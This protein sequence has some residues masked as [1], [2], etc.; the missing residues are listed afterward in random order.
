MNLVRTQIVWTLA[1]VAAFVL[2]AE[3]SLAGDMDLGWD[4]VPQSDVAG[5][6]ISYDTEPGGNYRSFIDTSNVTSFTLQG[7]SNCTRYHVAIRARDTGGLLSPAFSN[8][9]SGFPHPSIVSMTPSS[10]GRGASADVVISGRNF[11]PG[12]TATLPNVMVDSTAVDSCGQM[13]VH[14]TVGPAATGALTLTVRNVDGSSA[15]LPG[16]LLVSGTPAAFEITSVSPAAGASSVDA[17]QT[18]QV[19]FSQPVKPLTVTAPRFRLIRVGGGPSPRLEAGTPSLDA[20]GTTVSLRILGTLVSGAFYYLHVRGG[21][22]GVLDATG[23]PLGQNYV[24]SP[25]FKIAPLLEGTYYGP[26][27]MVQ[28]GM[29]PLPPLTANATIPTASV[30]VVKFT[31]PVSP[32]SVNARAF[33]LKSGRRRV[34]LKNNAPWLS[35]DGLSVIV[36]TVDPLTAGSS[37]TLT[38][39]GGLRGVQSARGVTMATPQLRIPFTTVVSAIEGLGV[40]E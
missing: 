37:F 23:I 36:E 25:G 13:T 12:A 1:F 24:Q 2:A 40:A 38:I 33:L 28:P 10:L 35:S 34:D 8:E 5:Y 20:A 27:G 6:R 29:P 14:I 32:T 26:P 21:R 9:I 39:K 3:P 4:P 31:E 30:L 18:I 7:L 15:T 22:L 17:E 16:A 19:R 11:A